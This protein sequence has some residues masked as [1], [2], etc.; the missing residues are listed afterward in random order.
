MSFGMNRGPTSACR[1][2]FQAETWAR[3][4]Q[5]RSDC[6]RDGNGNHRP[7]VECGR[8]RGAIGLGE[9][10]NEKGEFKNNKK[11]TRK[12]SPSLRLREVIES[13]RRQYVLLE[14]LLAP[15]N[16]P[17]KGGETL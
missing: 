14:K 1:I 7:C 3:Q 12:T 2:L 15:S 16:V 13:S 11:T 4:N 5:L 6:S 9:R 17:D 8:N 10:S